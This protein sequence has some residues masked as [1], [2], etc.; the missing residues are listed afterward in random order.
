[1]F[2]KNLDPLE[3]ILRSTD[4]EGIYYCNS[5]VE[6]N[7]QGR[8]L[9]ASFEKPILTSSKL[10]LQTQQIN[11][12]TIRIRIKPNGYIGVNRISCHWDNNITYGQLGDLIIGG[13][14]LVFIR[15]IFII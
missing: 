6:L 11:S 4:T 9:L 10:L 3:L 15:Y 7:K 14:A 1:M 5:R 13:I 12:T 8:K 2:F